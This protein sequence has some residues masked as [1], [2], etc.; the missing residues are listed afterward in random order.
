MQIKNVIP[1]GMCNE[2]LSKTWHETIKNCE[3]ILLQAGIGYAE[4]M[5]SCLNVFMMVRALHVME[6]FTRVIGA[7]ITTSSDTTFDTIGQGVMPGTL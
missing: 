1:T 3:K 2:A 4:R 7:Y 5:G 6:S